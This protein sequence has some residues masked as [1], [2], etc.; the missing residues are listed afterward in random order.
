[1][2]G[3]SIL[4]PSGDFSHLMKMVSILYISYFRGWIQ[5]RRMYSRQV[6]IDTAVLRAVQRNHASSFY[7]RAISH[8]VTDLLFEE[9]TGLILVTGWMK[10]RWMKKFRTGI[11]RY[12]GKQILQGR[13]HDCHGSFL[14][15]SSSQ[16]YCKS[17]GAH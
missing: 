17:H 5:R 15:Q 2:R 6:F 13:W 4:A 1:M 12:I 3:F 8:Q 16:R 14:S 11:T 9:V 7:R 10:K